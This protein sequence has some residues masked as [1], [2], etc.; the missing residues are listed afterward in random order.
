VRQRGHV[1]D[2]SISDYLGPEN[3]RNISARA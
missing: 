2:L 3:L 1:G